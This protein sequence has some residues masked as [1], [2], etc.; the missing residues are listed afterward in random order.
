LAEGRFEGQTEA[1]GCVGGQTE[2]HEGGKTQKPADR[3]EVGE[4]NRRGWGG[5]AGRHK[6]RRGK[7]YLDELSSSSDLSTLEQPV[8]SF[9]AVSKF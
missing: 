8:S 5:Q 7:N 3:H 9:P 4:A 6:G 2:R 1:G